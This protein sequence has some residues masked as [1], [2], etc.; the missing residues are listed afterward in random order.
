MHIYIWIF[1]AIS[2]IPIAIQRINYF[3]LISS[4]AL[5]TLILSIVLSRFYHFIGSASLKEMNAFIF[6]DSKRFWTILWSRVR[7]FDLFYMNILL[8][9]IIFIKNNHLKYCISRFST[10]TSVLQRSSKC[11]FLAIILFIDLAAS[12]V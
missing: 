10:L 1:A 11:L 8:C 7:L 2:D 6:K 5:L 9:I 3:T 4:K 12:S